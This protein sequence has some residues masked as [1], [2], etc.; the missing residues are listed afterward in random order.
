MTS[1]LPIVIIGG[2]HAAARAAAELRDIGCEEPIFI[3]GNEEVIPYERPPLSKEVISESVDPAT[4]AVYPV[5]FYSENHIELLLGKRVSRVDL[6]RCA[7]D[8]DGETVRYSKLMICLGAR[9]RELNISGADRESV[10]YL[11]SATDALIL[12]EKL[13]T[14]SRVI[15]IGGGFLGLEVAASAV[16][17]GCEVTVLEAGLNV[18]GRGVSPGVAS[19]LSES[20]AAKA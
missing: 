11:R 18:L 8:M 9:P 2:G 16:A 5:E 17:L 3:V 6:S 12:R 7:V 19:A 4:G 10:L 15:I 20:T 14:S 1:N 13:S